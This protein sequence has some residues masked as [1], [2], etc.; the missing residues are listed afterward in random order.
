[1]SVTVL[2]W[3]M[4]IVS[5]AL[6]PVQA[7]SNAALA[8][9]IGANVPFAALTLFAV[10]TLATAAAVAVSGKGFP[11]AAALKTAPWW[12]YSGGFI[13]AFY[14]FTITFLSPRLGVGTAIALVVT[15]QILAALTID[16]FGLMRSLVFHLTPARVAGAALMILGAFIALKR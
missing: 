12:S 16:H 15:G 3:A 6:I 8:R 4:A 2:L 13:V 9:A 10:A 1:M 11:D 5:G 14:V 7:A